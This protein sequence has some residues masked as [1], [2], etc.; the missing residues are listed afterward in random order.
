MH[1][2]VTSAVTFLKWVD[3]LELLPLN[4]TSGDF[5]RIGIQC[6][7]DGKCHF[8][9]CNMQGKDRLVREGQLASF[10]LE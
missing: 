10:N 2:G 6:L 1:V 3:R 7:K 5:C 4:T 8:N 9:H